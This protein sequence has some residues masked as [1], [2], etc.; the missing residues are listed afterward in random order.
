MPSQVDPQ[1]KVAVMYKTK[2]IMKKNTLVLSVLILR[3][4][5][6]QSFE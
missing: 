5:H 3:V 6:P 2:L 1:I 4:K